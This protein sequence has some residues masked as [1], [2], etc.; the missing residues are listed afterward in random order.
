MPELTRIFIPN[1]IVRDAEA[2]SAARR[3]PV[4]RPTL[5]A[6]CLILGMLAV[7]AVLGLGYRKTIEIFADAGWQNLPNFRTLD[8]RAKEITK[9]KMGLCIEWCDIG[10][11]RW[12]VVRLATKSA[13]F[14][15]VRHASQ[16][17]IRGMVRALH[18]NYV[19]LAL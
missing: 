18:T 15:N 19:E 1:E 9:A 7:K 10:R 2:K 11:R 17:A 6:T 5:H 13:P 3:N 8:W 12:L 14:M 4:G 16:S